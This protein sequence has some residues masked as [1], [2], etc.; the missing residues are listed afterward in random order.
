MEP[1]SIIYPLY[2]FHPF[3]PQQDVLCIQRNDLYPNPCIHQRG[4]ALLWLVNLVR[5]TTLTRTHTYIYIR[6][7]GE[8]E[9]EREL[10]NVNRK[11]NL[12]RQWASHGCSFTSS[13]VRARTRRI[14]KYKGGKEQHVSFEPCANNRL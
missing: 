4:H 11:Q 12:C 3:Q 14:K 7:R 9:R 13:P 10:R 8:R 6:S 2:S 5:L 1:S